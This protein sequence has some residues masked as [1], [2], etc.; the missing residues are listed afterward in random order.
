MNEKQEILKELLLKTAIE[1]GY[2]EEEL[3]YLKD[4]ISSLPTLED[5]R[6]K[7]KE[8]LEKYLIYGST[9]NQVKDE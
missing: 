7:Y 8:Q 1:K 4:Y 9:Q 2:T 3:T 5:L 6:N